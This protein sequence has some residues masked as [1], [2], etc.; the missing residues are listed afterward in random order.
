M[1]IGVYQHYWGSMGGGQRYVG[2]VAQILAEK[3]EVEILHHAADFD[4]RAFEEGMELDLSRVHFRYE[5]RPERNF[6][7]SRNP[8]RHLMNEMTFCRNYSEPYDLFIE[9]GDL[10]PIFNHAKRGVLIVNFPQMS[11]DEFNFHE[12]PQW[13]NQNFLKR[14]LK[15]KYQGIEWRC[16]FSSYHRY[17]CNSRFTRGWCSNRWGILPQ[18]LN[19]PLRSRIRAMEKKPLIVALGAFSHVNRKRQDVLID[20]FRIFCDTY[21]DKLPQRWTFR[22]IGACKTDNA[23]DVAFV[24]RLRE[25]AEGYPVEFVIN[26]DG[27]T[28]LESLGTATCVWYAMGY[29]VDEQK[30]PGETEPFGMIVTEAMAAG[31]IPLVYH[32]GGLSEIIRH[33]RNG[34]LWRTLVELITTTGEILQDPKRLEALQTAALEE[35]KNYDEDAFRANLAKCLRGLLS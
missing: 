5:P 28:L 20:A 30:Y 3:H 25:R 6:A 22:L 9:S 35:R 17:L 19:P 34:F 26:A 13:K 21:G 33:N 1:K 7:P 15:N 29:D 10:P 2:F 12:E 32:A 24:E 14:W 27:Q 31:A 23:E 11:F 16:R 18:V 4:Q 8:Y